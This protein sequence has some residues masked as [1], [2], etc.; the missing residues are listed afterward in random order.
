MTGIDMVPF[1]LVFLCSVAI[2]LVPMELG[3][4]LGVCRRLRRGKE[5]ENATSVITTGL[6][7][8]NSFFLA[9]IFGMAADRYEDR[10]ALVRE[11]AAVIRIAFFRAGI[12][13]QADRVRAQALL[14]EYLE[15]RVQAV[16]SG[17]VEAD[18][19]CRSAPG[20]RPSSTNCGPT[21][22]TSAAMKRTT[23]SWPRTA[24]RWTT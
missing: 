11:D 10:Q 17:D 4:R 19:C 18:P 21:P 3:H 12:L 8:L 23:A 20:C 14:R 13:P 22:R 16:A 1:W 2:V 5:R 7:S 15:E 24:M 9:F 6:V